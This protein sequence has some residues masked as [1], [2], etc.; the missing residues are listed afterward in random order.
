MREVLRI[1][2]IFDN[3]SCGS[4]LIVVKNF[5]TSISFGITEK[6]ELLITEKPLSEIEEV[7]RYSEGK[8][9]L[10]SLSQKEINSSFGRSET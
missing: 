10:K 5:F 7:C 6:R 1:K 9:L 3:D 8:I 4:L 2:M